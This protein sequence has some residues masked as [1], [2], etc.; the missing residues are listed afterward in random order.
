MVMTVMS[1]DEFKK[2]MLDNKDKTEKLVTA[3]RDIEY[4]QKCIE[5][6][7]SFTDEYIKYISKEIDNNLIEFLNKNGYQVEQPL[8]IQNLENIKE[9]LI[10][11]DKFI[12]YLYIQNNFEVND[13][14]SFGIKCVIVPFFNR[15]SNPLTEKDKD[16]LREEWIKKHASKKSKGWI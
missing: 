11:E 2:L 12:D 13:D 1:F 10:K 4:K 5:P 7:K 8:N 16:I 9:Q 14:N 15:I 6:I 3:I